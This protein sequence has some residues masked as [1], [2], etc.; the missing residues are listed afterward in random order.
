MKN[1]DRLME[2][3]MRL[4]F[5][6]PKIVIN[7]V[8]GMLGLVFD[9]LE[10]KQPMPELDFDDSSPA[11]DDLTKIS[12]IGPAFARRLSDAGV[13]SYGQLAGMT[14]EEVRS[15]AGLSEWQGDPDDWISQAVRLGSG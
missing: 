3:N 13:T 12:G 14:A 5:V 15:Q 9:Q 1:D 11:A 6:G 2:N 7:L 8:A 4:T 10:G